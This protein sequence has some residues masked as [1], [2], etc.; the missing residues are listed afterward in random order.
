M[1]EN[2]AAHRSS[3]WSW[4]VFAVALCALF[5]TLGDFGLTWDEPVYRDSQVFSAQW[6][7]RL[8][9]CRTR[10]DLERTL[11]PDALLYYWPYGRYGI[12]FHPPLAG[13][14]SLL[15]YEGLSW[16]MKDIPARRAASTIEFAATVAILFGFLARRFDRWTGFVAA[17]SL[18]LMP[19]LYGQAH[20]LDTDTPG[21]FLWAAVSSAFWKGLH[22]PGSRVWRASVGVLLGLAFLEKAAAIVVV[23]PLS[24][25]WISSSLR[26]LRR[27]AGRRAAIVDGFV[28]LAPMLAALGA[29][30]LEIRRLNQAF[31]DL[32]AAR[33]IPLAMRSPA[34]TNL[35]VDHPSARLPAT[36]LLVPP[37]VWVLR[38]LARLCFR[39]SPLWG[40]E[41]PALEILASGLAFPP[42]VGWFG[43]PA[44][45]RETLP[46][47]AHYHGLSVARKG[48]LPEIQILYF[49]RIYHYSLPWHNAW[50]LIAV[51]VPAT[52]LVAAALGLIRAVFPSKRR[53]LYL[54]FFLH[55]ITLP[56]L[57]MFDTPAH[58]GV[59][60]FLPAFYFLAG[61]AAWGTIG[62]AD[63]I[64]G[65]FRLQP[66][67]IRA[68]CSAL[69][70]APAAIQ[71]VAIHPYELSYYNEFVRGPANAWKKY[72]CELTYWY[73]AFTPGVLEEINSKLPAGA[74]IN[75]ANGESSP[76]DL[77]PTLQQ[78][79][80][81]RGDVKLLSFDSDEEAYHLRRYPYKWLLTNDAKASAF[82]RLLFAMRPF[83]ASRPR[84]LGG[85][86]VVT[87]AD[88]VAVSRARALQL[89]LDRPARLGPKDSETS[90]AIAL[91][92]QR[93]S[94]APWL[95]RF[96]G[97]GL[98]EAAPLSLNETMFAWAAFDPDGLR[99]AARVIS[100]QSAR[101][102]NPDAQR[103]LR[104]LSFHDNKSPYSRLLLE[105]RPQAVAEAIEILIARADDLRTVLTRFP[106]TDPSTIGGYLDDALSAKPNRSSGDRP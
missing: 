83:Y 45:W 81:L 99:A 53:A 43:N 102:L 90:G 85:A 44:W 19:R 48:V 100:N 51:T 25:W 40:G 31:L 73:D 106:Y 49:G 94:S 14:S 8:A 93:R 77:F 79:G 47:L 42:I 12:N 32:Q 41:R 62:S 75:F 30:F 64:A 91:S 4:A 84:Q 18:L 80:E 16:L 2:V 5:P 101:E 103:L 15:T 87:V 66:G 33:G 35:F 7:E 28:T 3:A 52:I 65:L 82:S 60:L 56:V 26:R 23:V 20:L 61:F 37:L 59:R 50:A 98:E 29:A 86:R 76:L 70:L 104:E 88:P 92:R 68:V 58:D 63:A 74:S 67:R 69:V 105:A 72:G 27:S 46:R 89:L 1:T 6:W 22:E 97:E 95:G 71:L 38:E 9:H 17:G 55:M 57:R 24:V 34:H 78:L 36:I 10:A 13:Q 96:R 11:D 21:L 39:K 54:Y